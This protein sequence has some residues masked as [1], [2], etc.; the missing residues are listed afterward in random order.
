MKKLDSMYDLIFEDEELLN[1]FTAFH[2]KNWYKM[3]L[4]DKSN[5]FIKINDR[6]SEIYEFEKLKVN[7][8]TSKL[9]YGS[10]SSFN[11]DISMNSDVL[12]NVNG[13]E[14]ADTYFHELRHSFQHRA[15]E[16][17]LS[18]KESVSPE[19]VEKWKENFLPGNYFGGTSKYYQFQPVESDAWTTGMLFA[20]AI[21]SKN[22]EV[23]SEDD[24]DWYEYCNCHKNEITNLVSDNEESME[25]LHKCEQEI[26]EIYKGKSQYRLEMNKGQRYVNNILNSYQIEDLGLDNIGILL[27]PYAFTY[28]Q[29]G[30][31]IR[32]L[33]RYCE[34]LKIKTKRSIKI[35]ENTLGSIK[36]ENSIYLP[37]APLD[38][39]NGILSEAFSRISDN[40]VSGEEEEY[41]ELNAKQK[42]E[43]ALNMYKDKDGKRINFITDRENLFLFSL[44]PYARYESHYILSKFRELKEIELQA[45]GKN[46]NDWQRMEDFYSNKKIFRFAS[47]LMN[48]KFED[49]Y[50]TQLK[51]YKERIKKCQDNIKL[52]KITDLKR[53]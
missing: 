34:L 39:V 51:V 41:K 23:I 19:L 33:K 16:G 11:W 43:I 40:L 26:K 52:E 7:N 44:Q 6:I 13:Y 18:S 4:E 28:L 36:I 50:K 24:K 32:V 17:R 3:S 20:R 49:Y 27:S 14:S 38:L 2:S 22:R 48:V 9:N 8:N 5:L 29:I 53:V 15:V 1:C 21:Y 35:C 46:C 10:Q 47:E 37:D 42:R 12:K 45:Y 30:D 31:K 25:F